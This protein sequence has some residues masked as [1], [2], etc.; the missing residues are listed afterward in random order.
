MNIFKQ[1]QIEYDGLSGTIKEY[2]SEPKVV[3]YLDKLK[4]GIDTGDYDTIKYSAEELIVWY[5]INMTKIRTNPY[6]TDFDAH[7]NN[8]DFLE[9]LTETL[10]PE[11]CHPCH[12]EN[13]TESD[14]TNKKKQIFLSHRSNDKKY[15]DAL[16]DFIIGLGVK[17]NQLI[18]S[19]HSLHKIPLD[20]NIFDYLRKNITSEIFMI[21]LWSNDYL[22]SPA[23]LNEMGA[24]WVVQ[25]DYTNIYVPTFNFGN[26][27]Y[28][29]CAVDTRKMGAVL[30]GD[31]HCRA[32]LI[33]LKNKILAMFELEDDEQ[34]SMYL[35]DQFIKKLTEESNH[36]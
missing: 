14:N 1:L 30:N 21:I 34:N 11:E 26:P 5:K 28:H 6:V 32:N 24:A 16:R 22:E 27:K 3:N 36:D 23:C 2:T 8:R 29:E 17:N 13:S 9:K 33:E 19:S 20:M 25:S 7:V 31:S 15:A 12:T 10:L 4:L 35:I 18:Y